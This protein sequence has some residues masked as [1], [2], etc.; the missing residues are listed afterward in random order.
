MALIRLAVGRHPEVPPERLNDLGLLL[1]GSTFLLAQGNRIAALALLWAAIAIDPVDRTAHRRLVAML[2]NSGD[3]QSALDEHARYREFLR[4]RKDFVTLR[5]EVAYA[6]ATLGE[7][8]RLR[9]LPGGLDSHDP[10]ARLAR[11]VASP[12]I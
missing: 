2:A 11:Y 9:L 6:A 12:T 1:S 7:V 10:A 3:L 4:A 8:M 5:N